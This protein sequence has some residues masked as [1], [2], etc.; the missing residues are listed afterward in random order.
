MPIL[1]AA[2]VGIVVLVLASSSMQQQVGPPPTIQ[3]APNSLAQGSTT[4]F[5][6]SKKIVNESHNLT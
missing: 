4:S 6:N 5:V 2:V 1:G 3:P